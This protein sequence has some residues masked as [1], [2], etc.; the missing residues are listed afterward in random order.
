MTNLTNKLTT[1]ASNA[2]LF[3]AGLVL[4][5]LGFAI[6]GSVA[7]FALMAVGVALVAAPFIAQEKPVASEA[8]TVA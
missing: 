4:A 2:V 3:T 7:L 6:V 1:A 5:G 8:E